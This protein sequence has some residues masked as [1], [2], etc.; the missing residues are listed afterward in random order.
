LPDYI[1]GLREVSDA[2]ILAGSFYRVRLHRNNPDYRLLLSICEMVHRYALPQA[3]GHGMR[4]IDFDEKQMWKVFQQF[5]TNF[6]RKKQNFYRVNPDAFPWLITQSPEAEKFSLPELETDIVLTSPASRIVIDSKF[7]AEPFDRRYDK[8]TVKPGHL[9]Q[10]FAYMQNLAARDDR[11]RHV[12]GVILYAAVS[13]A[14]CQDWKLFRHNLRVAG[15]DLS[16]DWMHIENS[17]LSVI[18]IN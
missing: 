5:I 13:G 4:F 18:G 6:Y 3:H 11:R 10:I 8:L 12:D 15:V 9:N 14:F 1:G 17:L 7:F 16:K 2:R